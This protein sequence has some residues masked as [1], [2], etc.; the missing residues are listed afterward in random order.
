MAVFRQALRAIDLS[1]VAALTR[2]P[3]D[4]DDAWRDPAYFKNR[5][6]R[7]MFTQ[8]NRTWL[9]TAGPVYDKDSEGTKGFSLFCGQTIFMLTKKADGFR[10]EGTHP[11][12]E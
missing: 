7:P 6:Y 2:M 4:C 9:R 5:I 11:D 12:D 8:R 10:F 3:I 1:A